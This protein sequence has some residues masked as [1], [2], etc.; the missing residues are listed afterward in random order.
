MK[1]V[2]FWHHISYGI[3][4]R[5]FHWCSPEIIHYLAHMVVL[6]V[7]GTHFQ[8][9][10][11]P[12]AKICLAW[13]TTTTIHRDGEGPNTFEFPSM[14]GAAASEQASVSTKG[15]HHTYI[16]GIGMLRQWRNW[17]AWQSL[18]SSFQMVLTLDDGESER[19]RSVVRCGA[20]FLLRRETSSPRPGLMITCALGQPKKIRMPWEKMFGL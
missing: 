11:F 13:S 15:S 16:N 1:L 19:T 9:F 7:F 6:W 20:S 2:K 10:L 4:I 14:A 12:L 8:T 5:A 17:G 3:R 18:S